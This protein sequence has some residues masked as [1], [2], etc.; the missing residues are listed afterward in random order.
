VI[1]PE[2]AGQVW[3]ALAKVGTISGHAVSVLAGSEGTTNSWY[4]GLATGNTSNYVLVL[5]LENE[6]D[7]QAA[8]QIG[9]RLLRTALN[10]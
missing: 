7:P 9:R 6:A 5:V 8:A 1:A 4:A 10:E 3:S 2:V